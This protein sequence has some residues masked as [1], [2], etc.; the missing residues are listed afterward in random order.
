M[1]NAARPT[2]T[3]PTASMADVAFLL[4]VFFLLGTAFRSEVGLRTD[5]PPALSEPARVSARLAVLVGPEG[6]LA[7]DGEPVPAEAVRQRV[8]AFAGQGPVVLRAHREAPY[9]DYIAALDAVL[10]GHQDAGVPPR[11]ALHQPED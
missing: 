3:I 10:L 9:A 1:P 8:E 6:R 11:L 5:L 7:M 2:P 4:L